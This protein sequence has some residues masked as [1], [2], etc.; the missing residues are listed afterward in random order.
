MY[1]EK[2]NFILVNHFL[3]LSEFYSDVSVDFT[4]EFMLVIFKFEKNLRLL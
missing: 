4:Q 2:R 1:V 3:Y